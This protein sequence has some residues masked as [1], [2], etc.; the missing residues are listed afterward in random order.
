MHDLWLVVLGLSIIFMLAALMVPAASRLNFPYTVLLAA[1]GLALG[2]LM[3]LANNWQTGVLGDV[4]TA[5]SDLQI[6]SDMVLFL[7]LPALIFESALTI[8]VRKLLEDIGPILALAVIGLLVS[9]VAVGATLHSL[10]GVGLTACLLLGAIVSATDPVAVIAIFK[11]LGA[12]KRL[13]ILVEGESLFNDAT[14]IV[15]FTILLGLLTTADAQP[16]VLAGLWSFLKV[17]VGGVIVGWV[18]ARLFCAILARL[19][20]QALAET[21]LTVSLAYLSFIIAEHYLH[22]SGVMA[23]VSAALVMGSTGRTAV[24][25]SSWSGLA[26]TWGQIGF[27]ANSVIFILVGISVPSMMAT[28]Q[29]HELIWLGVLILAAF[30]ARALVIYGMLPA[31]SALGLAQRIG[32]G[33]RSVMFWGGLRGAV[34]LALALAV[35]ENDQLSDELRGFIGVMVTGFVMFTLFVNA[36]TIRR[37]M[38]L[39]G[40]DRLS[41]EDEAIRDAALDHSARGVRQ[42]IEGLA[43]RRGLGAEIARKVEQEFPPVPHARG[44]VPAEVRIRRA[45]SALLHQEREL[46]LEQFA[47]GAASLSPTRRALSR[48]DRLEDGLKTAGVRGYQGAVQ[49]ML[50][51]DRGF[52]IA[53]QL[54]HRLGFEGSLARELAD[55]FEVLNAARAALK[56]LR[57]ERL[58]TLTDVLGE[59]INGA[60][61]GILD[62]R[63]AANGKALSAL[64]LQYPDYSAELQERHLR[65]YALRSERAEFKRDHKQGLIGAEVYK[66]LSKR[67]D[68]AIREAMRRPHLDLGVGGAEL[69]SKVSLFAGLNKSDVQRVAEML[70]PRVALPG[71]VLFRKG[72]SADRMFFISTG[73]VEVSLPHSEVTL[74]SGD[75]F[76]EIALISDKPRMATVTSLAFS[77]L[78]ELKTSDFRTLTEQNPELNAHLRD[79]AE[80]RLAESQR[81]PNQ[82]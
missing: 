34:S 54:H 16:D 70:K 4:I 6:T 51:F 69:V 30:T 36:P 73:A 76:G 21:T 23:L 44:E 78:L 62:A 15:L 77:R 1:V 58:A 53:I 12:P 79:T 19:K 65:L 67:V 18:L 68:N 8:D 49:K 5:L 60:I 26:H 32:I 17:F 24:S 31:M 81:I 33:F 40:L 42:R 28:F 82:Q 48:M 11:D 71:A 55:R 50:G 9:T 41:P 80:A 75:F 57:D 10:T 29:S 13:T 66:D 38:S 56:V 22:V 7:F 2:L 72:D 37:V 61:E 14:A 46:Y 20:D 39:F 64:R 74:G 47:A 45:L 63:L 35:M 52:R 59:D 27:W 43:S 25:P 3:K